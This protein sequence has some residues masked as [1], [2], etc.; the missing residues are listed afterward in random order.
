MRSSHTATMA[1]TPLSILNAVPKRMDGPELL[2]DLVPHSSASGNAAIEYAPSDGSCERVSYQQLHTRSDALAAK[3]HRLVGLRQS[4][5]KRLIVPCFMPQSP[6]LYV[7]Q[8]AI[9]KAGG[10]FC[11][12][13]LDTPQERVRFIFQDTEASLVLTVAGS[14]GTLPCLHGLEIVEVDEPLDEPGATNGDPAMRLSVRPSQPA[15]VM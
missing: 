14:R 10:A 6:E 11:P 3:I 4:S 8:L 13:A 15:Y 1:R 2:H 5:N 12:V 7:S 9:L